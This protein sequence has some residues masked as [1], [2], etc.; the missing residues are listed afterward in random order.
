MG[1]KTITIKDEAYRALRREKKRDE[2]FSDVIARIT[3]ARGRLSECY[4]A[5]QMD[6][7]EAREI[8]STLDRYWHAATMQ[9]R[10]GVK[11]RS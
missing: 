6:D 4:G 1:T 11:A 2:S 8:L 7:E 5:W 3:S 10:K 9:L